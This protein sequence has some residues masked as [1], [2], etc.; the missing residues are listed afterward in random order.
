MKDLFKHLTNYAINKDNENFFCPDESDCDEGHKR[1]LSSVMQ[2]LEDMGFDTNL[3]MNQ[4]S[5]LIIKT[6]ISA[7]PGMVHMF[8]S[9]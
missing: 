6:L 1:S 4:I 2:T 9:C 8:R 5:D 7:W 3:L